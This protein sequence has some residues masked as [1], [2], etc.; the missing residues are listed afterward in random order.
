MAVKCD[1]MVKTGR[2]GEFS[3]PVRIPAL[4]DNEGYFY[5][6]R[7]GTVIQSPSLFAKAIFIFWKRKG[8]YV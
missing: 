6:N 1:F 5:P 2:Q 8:E 4:K 7:S 3:I